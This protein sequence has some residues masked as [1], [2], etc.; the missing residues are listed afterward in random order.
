MKKIL[1]F[2]TSLVL[3]FP[4]WSQTG[5][6]SDPIPLTEG[7]ITVN[8]SDQD[9]VYFTYT[10]AKDEMLAFSE[11]VN[12]NIYT[13][14]FS[15][16]DKIYGDTFKSVTYIQTQQGVSYSIAISKGF[17]TG[18]S[19]F[20]FS[21]WASPWPEADNWDNALVPTDRFSYLPITL[22]A[23]GYIKYTAADDGVLSVFMTAYT[24]SIKYATTPDGPFS[25]LTMSYVNGGG[26]KGTMDVTKGTTYYFLVDAYNSMLCS[27]ELINPQ[28]G[29]SP[30]FPFTVTTSSPGIF[31]KEAGTYYYKLVTD[32]YDGYLLILGDGQF[33]GKAE[34]TS[35]ANFTN[36]TETSADR[37]HIRLSVSQYYGEY[38]LKLTRTVAAD[39]D[40]EF[41]MVYSD[42][43]YD[44]FPGQQ[45]EPGS[46]T[47]PDFSGLYYYT[48]TVPQDGRNIITVDA[49]GDDLAASTAL[50]LYYA[51][52]Q[53]SQLA[54]GTSYEYEAAP[55]RAYSLM[56]RVAPGNEPLRFNLGFR[57][58]SP[59]E[60]PS[61]PIEAQLG[62]NTAESDV[63]LYFKY[64]ATLDGWLY[65][66]PAQDLKMPAVSMLP[67]PSDPYTQ[68]CEVIP[69]DDA[70][71]VAV[72]KDRG[73]LITFY[74]TGSIGFFLTEYDAVKG[75]S[76]SNPFE[77]IDGEAVIPAEVGTFWYTFTSG[78]DGK[79]DISTDMPFEISDSRQ[80]YS[81]V[82]IY[83]PSDPDNFIS[84]LRPDY[85]NGYF[86]PRVLD[87][88][89]GDQYLIKV[90][91]MQAK[92]GYTVTVVVRDPVAGEVPG[93]PIEIP[94]NGNS[95]E[96]EFDRVVNYASDALW[97]SIQLPV[98]AFSMEGSSLGSFQMSM[99]E[100][101][102]L[103]QPIAEASILGVDYDDWY[104][105]FIYI[106]GVEGVEIRKAGSYLMHVTDN[107]VPFKVSMSMTGTGGI[108]GNAADSSEEVWH[109]LQGLRLD[110]RPTSPGIYILNGRKVL[111]K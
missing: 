4:A 34:A 55:G 39:A 66:T 14:Q 24:S 84:E 44:S 69:V 56:V 5:T 19:S 47:T 21:K 71:R 60:S 42:Q 97:Y 62:D 22:N 100:P 41:S 67:I 8:F 27:F 49:E 26:Y 83:L 105:M 57:A 99:Y 65:I 76:P 7:N 78:R 2:L 40:Q 1:L 45:I 110:R 32:N 50:S 91:T 73:Y 107:A 9:P 85:D 23:K 20:T 94:F 106:W 109:T 12:V 98:G 93:L 90:R 31:P 74:Q 104:Q 88:K 86:A 61:N 43:P 53:Y 15:P 101:D 111:I 11:L 108:S 87:T 81:Y 35:S 92:E 63:Q 28:V 16:E 46:Y 48:F 68:A 33:A 72:T 52:N 17:A 103:N 75:E 58:P 29:M 30:E 64:T 6:Q 82:R 51:D 38:Y 36:F 102:D 25:N 70:Y 79:L 95:G 89:E 37:I 54:T 18:P 96:Y 13:Y 80:D 59:G 77:V 10:P 3:W